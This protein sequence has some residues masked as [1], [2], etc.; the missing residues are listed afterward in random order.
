MVSFVAAPDF[1]ADR[2]EL[3]QNLPCWIAAAAGGD[4]RALA[5]LLAEL[6]KSLRQAGI[7]VPR[8]RVR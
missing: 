6:P 5:Q 4:R 8:S 3:A 2:S 7:D 1:L